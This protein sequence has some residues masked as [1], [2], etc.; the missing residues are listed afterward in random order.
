MVVMA[1]QAGRGRGKGREE[2]RGERRGGEGEIRNIK[3]DTTVTHIF[4]FKRKIYLSS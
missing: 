1:M 4:P 2:R 3:V